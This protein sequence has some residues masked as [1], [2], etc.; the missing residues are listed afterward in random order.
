M[1]STPQC[2]DRSER[3]ALKASLR[4]LTKE[5]RVREKAA[6]AAVVKQ[7]D[8]LLCTNTG[9]VVWPHLIRARIR[10]CAVW[11][12]RTPSS[13]RLGYTLIKPSLGYGVCFIRRG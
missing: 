11:N 12:C 4:E 8:V 6:V 1:H 2:K 3:F 7:A 13:F 10:Y 9:M 5:L